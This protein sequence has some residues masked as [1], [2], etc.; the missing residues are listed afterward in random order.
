MK[1]FSIVAAA[2]LL[3]VVGA[4][5]FAQTTPNRANQSGEMRG[6]ER[7]GQVRDQN[8]QRRDAAENKGKSAEKRASKAKKDKK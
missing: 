1:R 8:Q 6:A 4:G 5:A 3:T 7:A 2:A